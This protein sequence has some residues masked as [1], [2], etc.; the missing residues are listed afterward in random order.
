M[1]RILFIALFLVM[2][3][4]SAW[5]DCS[6]Y[7]RQGDWQSY[8][9]CM[10]YNYSGRTI[11]YQQRQQVQAPGYLQDGGNSTIRA[12]EAGRRARIEEDRNRC[13]QE[14]HDAFMRSYQPS[15]E[16][17]QRQAEYDRLMQKYSR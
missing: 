5:A 6:Q 12:I 14:A 9:N 2:A 17:Q 10:R 8:E 13:E 11:H 4:G 1:K 16:E 15:N 7:A 3:A